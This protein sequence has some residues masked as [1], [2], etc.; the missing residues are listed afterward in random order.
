MNKQLDKF[1]HDLRS[2][3]YDVLLHL[4]L[5]ET[6][7]FHSILFRFC[8]VELRGGMVGSPRDA[9]GGL[10]LVYLGQNGVYVFP[11]FGGV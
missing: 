7:V 2:V 10:L 3:N 9:V 6:S 11:M 8:P 4:I 1:F 5:R